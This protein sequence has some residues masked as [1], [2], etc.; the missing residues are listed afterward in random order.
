MEPNNHQTCRTVP[1]MEVFLSLI[2]VFWGWVK[3]PYISRIHTAY[4]GEDSYILGTE[5]NVCVSPMMVSKFRIA[6]NSADF[7]VNQP[8]NFRG[9]CF[10]LPTFC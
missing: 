7:Q 6:E 1:K 9:V 8:L 3:L 2:R 4:I 5:R 10:L